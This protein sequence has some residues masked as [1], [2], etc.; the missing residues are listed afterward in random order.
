ML[1]NVSLTF[2]VRIWSRTKVN[3]EKFATET[4]AKV[5]DTVDEATQNADIICTCTNSME[6]VLFAKHV[7]DGA[8]VNGNYW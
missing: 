6:P 4:G 7:K 5:C 2:Q 3:S 8:H 1:F